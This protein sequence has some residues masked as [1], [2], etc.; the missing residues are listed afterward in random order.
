MKIEFTKPPF[1]SHII[2]Y[3]ISTNIHPTHFHSQSYDT[4]L[5]FRP[6]IF[7]YQKSPLPPETHLN[8]N[9][10]SVINSSVLQT[11]VCEIHEYDNEDQAL[12]SFDQYK[13]NLKRIKSGMSSK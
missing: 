8:G 1:L 5:K 9:V 10:S 2:S 11:I 6:V 3:S 7:Y 13:F 12:L 4:K